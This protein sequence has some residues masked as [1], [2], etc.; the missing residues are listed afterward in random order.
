MK[1]DIRE[2]PTS[3]INIDSATENAKLMNEQF[4]ALGFTS[5][6]RLSASTTPAPTNAN[7]NYGTHYMGCGE[8][9]IMC[10]ERHKKDVPFLILEDDAKAVDNFNPVFEVPDDAGAVY[11]GVSLSNPHTLVEDVGHPD[12]Y[13]IK[14][15]LA[16]HAILYI[17]EHFAGVAESTTKDL[18]WGRSMPLDMGFAHLQ[19]Q[20]NVYA[21]KTPLFYQ[22]D[23]RETTNNNEHWTNTGTLTPGRGMVSST[24]NPRLN[25]WINQ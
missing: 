25:T 5:H 23:E 6:E 20:W 18:I 17:G 11:L 10:F 9:H 4:D 8:S 19:N 3:W 13:R 12:V 14:N 16:T 7:P 15:V 21:L 2:V 22:A 1:I 24:K